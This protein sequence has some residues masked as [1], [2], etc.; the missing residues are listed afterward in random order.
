MIA[1]D[2]PLNVAR[3]EKIFKDIKEKSYETSKYIGEILGYAP[4]FNEVEGI[5]K[6]RN[7]TLLAI[8]PTTSSS[9]ILGQVSPGIEPYS[10]NYY[11]AGLAKGNFIRKNKYLEK[12][13]EEKNKNNMEIWNS[14]MLHQGSV[15]HLDFLT[16][17]EKDVFKTFS[18]INQ[19]SIIEQASARQKYIDQ[20]QSLNINIPSEIPIKDVNRLILDAWKLG[21]KTLYYQRSKSVAKEMISNLVTCS[22]CEA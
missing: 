3:N 22:S 6:M 20:S 12:L 17:E 9:A 19:H 1:F 11:K 21:V 5:E 15:Q 13:L 8:A 10:S 7:T 4:I 2:D 16:Q 14:I 18:E